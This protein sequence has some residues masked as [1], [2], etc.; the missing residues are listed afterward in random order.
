MITHQEIDIV[1]EKWLSHTYLSTYSWGFSFTKAIPET[2]IAI[3]RGAIFKETYGSLCLSSIRVNIQD[4]INPK[5]VHLKDKYILNIFTKQL[6]SEWLDFL[7]YDSHDKYIFTLKTNPQTI[8]NKIIKK[9][10]K[11]QE[12]YIS[13]RIY[14]L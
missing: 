14:I 7:H 9:L 12:N 4:N 3:H 8:R 5:P 2:Y 1:I 6:F 13:D 11:H 10:K